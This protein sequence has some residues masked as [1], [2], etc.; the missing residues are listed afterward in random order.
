MNI[1]MNKK[2]RLVPLKLNPVQK[3]PLLQISDIKGPLSLSSEVNFRHAVKS[4]ATTFLNQI[5]DFDTTWVALRH[6]FD[7]NI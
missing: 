3:L 5:R 6:T 2:C 7:C 4:K 1:M